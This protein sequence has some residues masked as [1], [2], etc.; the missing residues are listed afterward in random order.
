MCTPTGS[1]EDRN[2]TPHPEAS[3]RTY[4][5]GENYFVG[6]GLRRSADVFTGWPLQRRRFRVPPPLGDRV[7]E[8][9]LGPNEYAMTV[10]GVLVRV[11]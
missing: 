1:P 3:Q 10:M 2:F 8:F 9:L 4:L 7:V 11:I 6:A 5:L